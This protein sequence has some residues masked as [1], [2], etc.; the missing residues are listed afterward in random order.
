MDLA[1]AIELDG[2]RS[3][4]GVVN[5]AGTVVET[6][7][8]AE[9]DRDSTTLDQVEAAVQRLRS[10]ASR[11][12][13]DLAVCGVSVAGGDDLDRDGSERSAVDR[14]SDVVG[15]VGALPV[16]ADSQGRAF[17]LAEGWVGTAKGVA[18]YAALTIGDGVRGGVVL[19]GRLLD[20]GL[21]RA[22]RLGHVIV[23]PDGRRCSCGAKGCLQAE[24]SIGAIEA[25][26]GRP[27][28]EPSYEVMRHVGQLVGRA[29]A[30]VANLL[31]LKL[32]VCGGRVPREYASTLFLAAQEELD[33][34]CRLVFSKGARIASSRTPEPAGLVGAAAIGWRGL[35]KE[36]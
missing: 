27:L 33:A 35:A 18:H 29:A 21:G 36:G 6:E 3:T 30:S 32:I 19:D 10:R 20:G 22:G 15:E 8:V 31:D 14:L 13:G 4:L 2:S 16:H 24:V 25:S 7:P 26:T 5:R 12:P 11:L 34:S 28:S 23:V 1:L 17:A 9:A